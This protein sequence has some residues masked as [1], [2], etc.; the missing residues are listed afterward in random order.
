M[1]KKKKIIIMSSLV[2]LLALTAVLNVLLATN[3]IASGD[4]AVTTSNYFTT[5]RTE[6]TTS[7]SEELLQLDSVIA[8]YEEDSE[9]YKEAVDL[10]LKI[11]NMM[12]NEL[13]LETLIK[14]RGFSDAV[15]SIGMNSDNVN[16]FVNSNELNYNTAM[17]IYTM[18]KDEVGVAPGS[19][20][21]LPVYSQV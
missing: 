3:V 20:I 12:E 16:V 11:V 4:S 15:V 10:K 13:M 8:L 7:R 21:I 9:K 17:A 19:I 1:S 6:R 14:S 2:F 5:F 18:L